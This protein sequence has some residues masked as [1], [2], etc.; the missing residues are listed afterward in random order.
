MGK[1][2]LSRPDKLIL[3]GLRTFNPIPLNLYSKLKS[4]VKAK[5]EVQFI[6]EQKLTVVET[7]LYAY[8]KDYCMKEEGIQSFE[9]LLTESNT[10][11]FWL[12]FHGLHDLSLFHKLADTI[13]LD[14]LTLRK[15][16]DTTQRSKVEE[17]DDYL[18]FSIKS[19][20]KYQG[21]NIA[22]EQ[23]YFILGKNFV[24]SFQEEKNDHFEDIRNKLTEGFGV[25]RKKE[26]DFLLYQLLD[27]ILDNY[28]ETLDIINL[29]VG[30]L[31]KETL[32]NPSQQTLL[33]LEGSKKTVDLI[34]KSMLPIRESMRAILNEKTRFIRKANRKYYT[35]LL[36]NCSSALEE[37]D[38]ISNS[39]E[40][41]TNLYFSALSQKMNETMKVLTTVAT[42]FIPLTFIAGIYGM[43]FEYMPE[44]QMR[45]GYFYAL[46]AMGIIFI[47]MII[48]FKTKK[49]L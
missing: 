48:Y 39:L 31:E 9:S 42:I 44:L 34:K 37:I 36:N 2:D 6:G 15:I 18:S 3:D 47:V 30:L 16:P 49:W 10:D 23:L 12:N 5:A 41:L 45:N 38:G 19:I 40:G 27:A 17:Y 26:S 25:I 43:N 4:Q 14:Q 21:E 33:A 29:E 20:L 35:D 7:Q 13:K 24:I 8:G 22:I 28:F 46:G 11:F 1:Y 32:A